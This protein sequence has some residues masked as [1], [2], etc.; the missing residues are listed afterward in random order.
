MYLKS[1]ISLPFPSLD[2]IG[3]QFIPVFDLQ[4]NMAVDPKMFDK[5]FGFV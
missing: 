4:V 5:D 1:D 2:K 3:K